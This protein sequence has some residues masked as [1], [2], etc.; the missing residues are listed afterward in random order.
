M[1]LSLIAF[2]EKEKV[3]FMLKKKKPQNSGC[4]LLLFSA[5]ILNL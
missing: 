4:E 5:E 1:T 2:M 3:N